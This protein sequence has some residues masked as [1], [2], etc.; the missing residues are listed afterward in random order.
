MGIFDAIGSIFSGAGGGLAA[1]AASAYGTYSTNQANRSIARMTNE[2][3]L[4]NARE[5]MAFS[6]RMSNTQY[7]RGVADMKAAGINPMLAYSQG[8]AS[9]PSGTSAQAIAGAN[10]E[11]AVSAGVNSAIDTITTQAQLK[12]LAE[13]NK[14]I[15][16]QVD[17]TKTDT[18]TGRAG[19]PAAVAEGS[20]WSW[21]LNKLTK[22]AAIF[23][24]VRK[25]GYVPTMNRK[26]MDPASWQNSAGTVKPGHDLNDHRTFNKGMH[27]VLYG[28]R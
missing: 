27:K 14:L 13:Q 9:S 26:G 24:K 17:K 1:G 5:A 7:Q 22:G 11:N 6:E 25:P 8:G 19:L 28:N 21:A 3:G 10:Q 2:Y 23:N 12:N 20:I 4:A 16:A 18:A 15:K